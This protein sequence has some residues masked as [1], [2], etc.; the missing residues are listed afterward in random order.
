MIGDD[1]LFQIITRGA[2]L[3]CVSIKMEHFLT[4]HL[5]EDTQVYTNHQHALYKAD[6]VTDQK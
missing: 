5:S 4:S 1:K 6:V 2:L 3:V